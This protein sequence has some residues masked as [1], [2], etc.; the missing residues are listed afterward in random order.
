[1]A[2]EFADYDNLIYEISNE[3]NSGATWSIISEYAN[4]I[5]PIIREHAPNAVVIVG[6][7]TWSQD[8]D[9]ALLNPLSYDNIMYTLHFY[10]GTHKDW[11]IKRMEQCINGGLPIFISEFGIC[12]A[13]GNGALDYNSAAAWKESIEKYNVSYMCWNLA[14]KNESSSI[15]KQ[16]CSKLSGWEDADLNDQGIWIRDWFLSETDD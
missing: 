10:A 12:D 13:S 11:L 5:I 1:M 9:K 4:R 15:L 14:N 2:T 3:P 7:P 16:S 8:V 6:T